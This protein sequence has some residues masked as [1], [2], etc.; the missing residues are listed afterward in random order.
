MVSGAAL[1]NE[2][3]EEIFGWLI[4][5]EDRKREIDSYLPCQTKTVEDRPTIGMVDM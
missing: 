4:S 2:I 5:Q 1:E 3:G